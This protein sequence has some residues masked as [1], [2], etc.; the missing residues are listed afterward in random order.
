[1]LSQEDAEKKIKKLGGYDKLYRIKLEA[2]YLNKLA[3]EGAH[4][5]YGENLTEEQTER[6]V[7]ELHIM[8]TMG[9]PGYF[10]IAPTQLLYR[11]LLILLQFRTVW[12]CIY[13]KK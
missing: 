10:L 2:D 4:M 9:F 7:F 6:I 5:R 12:D 3:W 8:K 1:M 11:P 13:P